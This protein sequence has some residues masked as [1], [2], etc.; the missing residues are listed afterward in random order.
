MI[1]R[2]GPEFWQVPF[3]WSP[4]GGGGG[5]AR[6]SRFQQNMFVQCMLTALSSYQFLFFHGIVRER[7]P[8]SLEGPRGEVNVFVELTY[9]LV[10]RGSSSDFLGNRSSPWACGMWATL[11]TLDFG[12]GFR[13]PRPNLCR[14]PTGGLVLALLGEFRARV[15]W[16]HWF[17]G[18]FSCL[19]TA[20]LL[21][22]CSVGW[23]LGGGEQ[24]IKPHPESSV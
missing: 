15:H 9:Y 12:F 5:L 11:F 21:L 13:G 6:P 1:I 4:F 24:R 20:T 10:P 18:V 23:V 2:F 7:L 17:A 3:S 16:W 19:F 22:L 14:L 8:S